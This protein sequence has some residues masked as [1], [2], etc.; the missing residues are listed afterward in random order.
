M[1]AR[2]SAYATA[3]TD[4]LRTSLHPDRRDEHDAE[5]VRDWA[6][7]SDWLGLEIVATTGGGE[8]DETGRVE[9]VCL[10]EYEGEEKRHHEVADFSRV[11]GRWYFVEGEAVKSRP[12]VREAP[13]VG[14]NDPCPCGSG[15]KHKRCCGAA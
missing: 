10:Y 13:K 12:F 5:A 6:E 14:R 7:G 1:R 15:K 11:D 8:G 9:F 2:Y 4:F 3:A